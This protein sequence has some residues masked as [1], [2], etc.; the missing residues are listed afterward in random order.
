MDELQRWREK[1]ETIDQNIMGMLAVR[2]DI[3]ERIGDWKKSQGKPAHDPIRQQQVKSEWKRQ[4]LERGM[5]PDFAE[6]MYDL[7][8][9]E[10]L[11]LEQ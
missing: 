6:K 5:N 8:H 7:I 1:I 2:F 3:A 4:A 9:E 10:A 11:R